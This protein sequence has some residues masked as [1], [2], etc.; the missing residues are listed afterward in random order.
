MIFWIII[1]LLFNIPY[2]NNFPQK[3][4]GFLWIIVGYKFFIEEAL[5]LL[6]IISLV[7][8][9]IFKGQNFLLG[10]LLLF[11]GV[12]SILVGISL[13]INFSELKKK[14][15]NFSFGNIYNSLMNIITIIAFDSNYQFFDFSK[16]LFFNSPSAKNN[17]LNI[18]S[19]I[20]INT[21]F[22]REEEYI[23]AFFTL[24]NF[25]KIFLIVANLF[26]FFF[27]NFWGE[28]FSLKKDNFLSRNLIPN[29]VF[30]ALMTYLLKYFISNEFLF[31]SDL[32][33]LNFLSLYNIINLLCYSVFIF[34]LI[35][36]F[37]FLKKFSFWNMC[38]FA[39]ILI[40]F[41]AMYFKTQQN[42]NIN[43]GEREILPPSLNPE[44][45]NS[46]S[47]FYFS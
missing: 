45:S 40:N 31:S 6:N 25:F 12:I 1:S 32:K 37:Y 21:D 33:D 42:L 8:F 3:L 29:P 46:I 17:N 20:D 18:N 10:I 43:F 14:I 16:T 26:P 30:L 27:S 19:N 28:I 23:L 35:Y 2:Q 22:F 39:L 47:Y 44:N 38:Y 36:E 11:L 5:N 15:K 9:E 13:L 34:F 7:N 4:L 24:E 41:I